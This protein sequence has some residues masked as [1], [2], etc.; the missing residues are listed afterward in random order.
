MG[1]RHFVSLRIFQKI[2]PLK[3]VVEPFDFNI[4]NICHTTYC[5][6]LIS[7]LDPFHLFVLLFVRPYP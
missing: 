6:G 3:T 4:Y 1:K 5:D 7:V 2:F